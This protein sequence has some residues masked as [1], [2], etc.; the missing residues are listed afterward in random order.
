MKRDRVLA[1]LE[2]CE[3]QRYGQGPIYIAYIN[4]HNGK[5]ANIP[6]DEDID[7]AI[8]YGA[9]NILKIEMPPIFKDFQDYLDSIS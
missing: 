3:C 4:P 9:C 2:F 1:W 7:K 8:I 6:N 5:I